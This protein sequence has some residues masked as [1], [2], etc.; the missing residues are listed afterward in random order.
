M[1]NNIISTTLE[2]QNNELMDSRASSLN[3]SGEIDPSDCRCSG[4]KDQAGL[5]YALGTIG[6]DF[7][8]ESHRDSFAQSIGDNPHDAKALLAYLKKNPQDAEELIWTLNIDST[9]IYAITPVGAH[10][11]TGYT[12]IRQFMEQQLNGTIQRISVP[13]ISKGSISLLNG[14]KLAHLI[15]RLRGMYSWTTSALVK[16]TTQ[17]TTET[18]AALTEKVTNFLNRIYYKVRN[19]GITSQERALN[20]AATNA[21]Q[22]SAVFASALDEH[23]ELDEISAVKSPIGKPGTDCYDVILTF[24][25]PKERLTQARKEYRLTIDVSDVIPTTVGEIR[26]WFVF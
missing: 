15:P 11:Q 17:S 4:N 5:V 23:L 25:N 24:F 26:S 1:E 8:S 14:Q 13:G 7:G 12:V 2:I 6:Y 22:V 10:S 3:P 16:A 9:P 19:L 18:A 20:Y 21:Y